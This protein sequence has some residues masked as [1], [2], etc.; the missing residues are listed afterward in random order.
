MD[1]KNQGQLNNSGFTLLEV[2]IA[3]IIL[4]IVSIP[5]LHAFVSSAQTTSKSKYKMYATNAAENIMED[6]KTLTRAGVVE[7][8]GTES[9]ALDGNGKYT[10]N[11]TGVAGG[12][13]TAYD[14]EVNSAL[15]KGFNVKIEI[16]PQ[17]YKNANAV[18]LS[19]FDSVSAKTA[20]ILNMPKSVNSDGTPGIFKDV[21]EE[22]A[23]REFEKRNEAYQHIYPTTDT[24]T[25]SGFRGKLYRE[26]SI[27]IDKVGTMVD[28][29][30]NTIDKV[31]VYA[32]ISYL[33]S[34]NDPKVVDDDKV[35]Y[36][37]LKK[38]IFNN[39]SS[40]APFR[41]VFI[42][43]QPNYET[44]KEGGDII[45]VHNHDSV[46][47]DLYVVAQNDGSEAWEDYRKQ[48]AKGGLILEIYENEVEDLENG[49]D[50]QPILLRTNLYDSADLEYLKTDTSAQVPVQCYLNI[51]SPTSDPDSTT[52]VF[53]PTVWN[54]I[55]NKKGSFENESA[56]KALNAQTTDGKTLDAS[57]ITDRI[58]DVT[59][60]V[61]KP[62]TG[63][64]WPVA[65]ELTGTLLE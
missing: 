14:S 16:D 2:L 29:D 59:V 53:T 17:F 64:E 25:A 56:S 40:K 21:Y 63:D 3:V 9:A 19:E 58:Y 24:V 54:R 51:G 31:S 41:S 20:A 28:A 15:S 22:K 50:K 39:A 11:I 44:A 32:T 42:M 65:V 27:D 34:D 8:Y 38:Q 46:E 62:T 60:T 47:A 57:T 49:G 5:V 30:G 12:T 10:L 61:E 1:Q 45:I 13:F 6:M 26:I 43:Y 23:C 55:K 33:L 48:S 36:V 52:A 4:A 18:N 7:K 37:A 35:S